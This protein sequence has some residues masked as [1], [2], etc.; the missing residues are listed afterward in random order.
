MTHITIHI[1]GR[2][3]NVFRLTVGLRSLVNDRRAGGDG[4]G[5]TSQT[6]DK[7]KLYPVQHTHTHNNIWR[8]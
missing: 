2:G 3:Y 8:P 1:I 6:A 4:F 5:V 7:E